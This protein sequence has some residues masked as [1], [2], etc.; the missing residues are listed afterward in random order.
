MRTTYLVCY[1]I[2]DAKRLRRVFK[3]CKNYGDHLQFSVFECDL[4]PTEK[5]GLESELT[6][7]IK[8]S[9]DQVIF[10]ALGPAEGRGDRAITALGV[11]YLKMDAPCYAY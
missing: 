10:V 2:A 1:D 6:D 3:V 4:S 5:A 8:A 11:P 7:I 9:E